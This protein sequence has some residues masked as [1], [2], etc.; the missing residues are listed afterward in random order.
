M[1]AKDNGASRA[2]TSAKADPTQRR[3]IG[4]SM[5]R[6]MAAGSVHV[7]VMLT[8]ISGCQSQHQTTKSGAH[9]MSAA[10]TKQGPA[11]LMEGV[12]NVYHPVSTSSSDAQKFFNQGLAYCY[13]FNHAEAVRS[14][15]RAYELDPGCAM[16]KWGEALAL[17]PN[18]NADVDPEAEKAAYDAAQKALVMSFGG[19]TSQQDRDYNAALVQRY[20]NDPKADLKKLAQNYRDAMENLSRKYPDDL[21]AATL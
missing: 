4:V 1:S 13:A 18:I 3:K 11:Q 17:G 2:T 15:Q 7:L 9:S 21:D 14:F 6:V 10:G 8:A 5:R 12:G 16:A 19:I 20:S